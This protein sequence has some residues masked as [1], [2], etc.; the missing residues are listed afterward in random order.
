MDKVKNSG[1]EIEDR[2]MLPEIKEKYKRFFFYVGKK[3]D[4]YAIY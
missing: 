3:D 4:D 1:L 2:N